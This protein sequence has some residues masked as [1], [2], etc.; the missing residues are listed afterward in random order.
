MDGLIQLEELMRSIGIQSQVVF[1]YSHSTNEWLII[2]RVP[3]KRDLGSEGRTPSEALA[4][5]IK[6]MKVTVQEVK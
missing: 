1:D 4:N 3:T 5:L 2:L 6:E